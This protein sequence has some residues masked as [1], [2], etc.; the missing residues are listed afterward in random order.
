MSQNTAEGNDPATADLPFRQLAQSLQ[1]PCWISDETGQIVWVN[2]AW[3]AYTG[4]SVERIRSSGLKELHDP[5]LYGEVVRRW[6][7]T[8][9]S[10]L[11]DEM[12][13][14]LR[15]RDGR[16]RPFHTRVVPLREPDGRISRWFGTNTDVSDRLDTE[17]RLRSR[18]EQWREVFERAGDAIFVADPQGRLIEVNAA[19]ISVTGYAAPE[20]IGRSVFELIVP[21]ERP[22]LAAARA[23]AE[24]VHEW[25]LQRKDGAVVHLEISSRRLSDGRRIGVARDVSARHQAHQALTREAAE[26]RERA[27]EAERHLARFWDASRDLFAVVSTRDGRPRLING[28]AWRQTLGY[29]AAELLQMRLFDL[30]HPD[31]VERTWAMRRA[32]LDTN[33]AGFENRYVAKD[34]HEVWLSWNVVREGELVYCSARDV[35]AERQSR[36]ELEQAHQRIARA[37]K[38]E[39]I[40]QLTGGVAHDFN[41][42]LMVIA[43]HAELLS[44]REAGDARITSSIDAISAAAQRGQELTRRLLTFSRRQRLNP[45]PV[46]LGSRISELHALLASSLG[47]NVEVLLD[48]PVDLWTVEIDASEFE[49]ALLNMA[50]NARD[51]MPNGGR[52]SVVARN[53][54]VAEGESADDVP[55]GDYV[56]I[57]VS[58]TGQGIPADIVDRVIEPYF[59]TKEVNQGTG[60]GLSQVDGFA[61][62]SGGRLRLESQLGRGT[63]VRIWLPRAFSE[64]GAVIA[65]PA[66]TSARRLRV[67][68]VEDNPDVAEVTARLLEQ[69]GHSVLLA[70]SATA[71]LTLWQGG[72]TERFDLVISD[73]V[74]A[75]EINGLG[76][77]RRVRSA[78]GPPVLLVTGYSR[79]AGAIGDEFPVL[80]KP[81]QLGELSQAIQL[82]IGTNPAGA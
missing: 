59:T 51:A 11:A 62:Q 5:S 1:V 52:F 33:Y 46:A 7:S 26:Q 56:E 78:G 38:M 21:D 69:L 2:D 66:E 31:D 6:M 82:A 64:V 37:Q 58:D 15:G 44:R 12:V 54:A 23:A 3:L 27:S 32:H 14:P 79:E 9:A 80:A 29:D 39:T 60:L 75:G 17:A 61:Q 55:A 22:D 49:A 50:V 48:C 10:G 47:A 24:S 4:W 74:M 71:A 70:G 63:T 19:A 67:L 81:Y 77:A 28:G 8:L 13:F 34:G 40:G 76:F 42:L 53:V 68:L 30:V 25:R 72:S 20:L 45:A 43:G 57:A 41:N 73:I 18:E 35:T 36:N 65:A 16:L